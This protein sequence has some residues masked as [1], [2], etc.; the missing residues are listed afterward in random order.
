MSTRTINGKEITLTD[1]ELNQYDLMFYQDNPRVYSILHENECD[2]P[3]QQQIEELMKSQEHVKEL[4]EQIKQHGGLIEPLIAI[5]KD[6]QYVVLEGNSRL[7]AYRILGEEKPL[8]WSKV[9]VELL[10]ENT[11]DDDIFSLLGSLH[12]AAKKEWS[13]FEKAAY[14]YRQHKLHP[15]F[16]LATIAKKA[17][18]ASN[19]VK[20]YITVYTFMKET[21]QDSVQSHWNC[22]EQYITNR[23]IQRYR[24]THPDMDRKV[25]LEIKS[26]EIDAHDIRDKMGKIAKDSG[27]QA[28]QIMNN[29]IDG[30]IDLEGAFVRFQSTGRSGNNFKLLKEM[31]ERLSSEDFQRA[32]LEEASQNSGIAFEI[33]KIKTIVERIF[34]EVQG[35]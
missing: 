16:P 25:I 20:K 23:D 8:E 11:S 24:D 5:K 2:D 30:N 26:K 12:L 3:S 1:V 31:R 15:N 21:A 4:R 34:R 29:Y 22:Y 19:T 18:L 28:A 6:N 13:V 33:K 7:A 14:V 32:I 35:S 9:R 10:P 17:G 27:R